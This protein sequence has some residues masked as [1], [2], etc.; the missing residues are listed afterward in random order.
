[1]LRTTAAMVAAAMLL[2]CA[3]AAGKRE[4]FLPFCLKSGARSLLL[5]VNIHVNVDVVRN[6]IA[7][8]GQ[9]SIHM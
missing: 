5:F 8:L 1:M 4:P 2:L 3:F 6:L 9:V 7:S